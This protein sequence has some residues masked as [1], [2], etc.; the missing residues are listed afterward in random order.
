MATPR[1]QTQAISFSL[2]PAHV[3]WLKERG[4]RQGQRG[5]S[6]VLREILDVEMAKEQAKQTE[7]AA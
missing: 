7:T 5:A 4:E 2:A 1:S 3:T 6:S